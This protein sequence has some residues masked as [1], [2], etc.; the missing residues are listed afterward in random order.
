MARPDRR[1]SRPQS[2]GERHR[3]CRRREGDSRSFALVATL[4]LALASGACA[5]S[6]SAFGGPPVSRVG[7]PVTYLDIAD[8]ATRD[9]TCV[10][11]LQATSSATAAIFDLQLPL[12][13]PGDRALPYWT[14]SY[15]A[16]A[17]GPEA[18]GS[19]G[20]RLT[21]PLSAA[22]AL[23]AKVKPSIVSLEV[24]VG[25]ALAGVPPATFGNQ[26]RSLIHKLR[27][28]GAVTILVADLPP[29]NLAP[30]TWL[31]NADGG[32]PAAAQSGARL[33]STLSAYDEQIASAAGEAHAT[34]VDLRAPL[35]R[36]ALD[37]GEHYV[38]G[39]GTRAGLTSAANAIV[40]AQFHKAISHR[41][42][43]KDG[44]RAP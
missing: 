30:Y 41:S 10:A 29:V 26:L 39:G 25:P 24:G 33:A 37:H 31:C 9:A 11:S 4:A 21:T 16:L 5:T 13:S 27:Q 3:A 8:Q 20:S 36:A 14:V 12:E 6:G 2:G 34:V 44:T 7:A 22:A 17:Y 23:A 38:F 40:E 1:P 18:S 19:T 43:N 15:S 32:C 35:S 42:L 28:D